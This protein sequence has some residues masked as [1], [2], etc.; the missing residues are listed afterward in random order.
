MYRKIQYIRASV[1]YCAAEKVKETHDNPIIRNSSLIERYFQS[2]PPSLRDNKKK[3]FFHQTQLPGMQTIKTAWN[4]VSAETI[5][6]CYNHTKLF[7]KEISVDKQLVELQN[8]GVSRQIEESMKKMGMEDESVDL[9]PAHENFGIK[10]AGTAFSVDL[11]EVEQKVDE[12][13]GDV[14]EIEEE[15]STSSRNQG[16][17]TA[18]NAFL[19]FCIPKNDSQVLLLAD[20]MAFMDDIRNEECSNRTT[21]TILNTDYFKEINIH[22]QIYQIHQ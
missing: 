20:I 7:D 22:S 2:L 15:I 4:N 9:L 3:N 5:K 13:T 21:Q 18:G 8:D 19:E 14:E 1:K 12:D 17:L 6:N 16:L 11:D 10:N